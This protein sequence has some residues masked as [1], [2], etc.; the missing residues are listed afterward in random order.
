MATAEEVSKLLGML[1]IL[2]Q[3]KK[4]NDQF[5]LIY[6]KFLADLPTDVVALA[7]QDCICECR[8]FPTI[9][10]IRERS[11]PHMKAF[12][13][14]QRQIEQVNAE[15]RQRQE[16][17]KEEE[18]QAA[19]RKQKIEWLISKKEAGIASRSEIELLDEMQ[20]GEAN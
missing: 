10:D 2:F 11:G 12:R 19:Y 18:C 17:E 16:K 20:A 6:Q 7:I 13:F 15:E 9:A 4:V 14:Q 8:F 5:I 3:E 1:V